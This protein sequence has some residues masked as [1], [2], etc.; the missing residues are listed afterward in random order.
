[1][2]FLLINVGDVGL[3]ESSDARYGEI[4]RAMAADGDYLHP[5]LLGI[6]HYHKPPLTY[7]IT[8]LG[9]HIFGVNA[10]AT[11][12]FLQIAC[13]IQMLLVFKLS[14][15]L[16]PDKHIATH[17]TTI[18][19][20]LPIVLI[21]SRDLT[22]DMYL[23][24]FTLAAIYFW[25]LNQSSKK[26]YYLL[27]C[28]IALGLAFLTKG[29]VVFI[30]YLPFIFIYKKL[31]GKKWVFSIYT[32]LSFL[33]FICIGGSWY[34]Y[35]ILKNPDFFQYF[36]GDQ[37]LS[38]FA[39]TA[40]FNRNM[41]FWYFI[42]L[43]PL[44]SLPWSLPYIRNGFKQISMSKE[45]RLLLFS[46]LIPLFIFSISSSKRLLYILPFFSLLSIWLALQLKRMNAKQQNKMMYYFGITMGVILLVSPLFSS[47]YCYLPWI[48]GVFGF[49]LLA[50]IQYEHRKIDLDSSIRMV[51]ATVLILILATGIFTSKNQFLVKSN[52]P[53]T[54]FLWQHKL[55]TREVYIYNS[56]KPS[57]N[58]GLKKDCI[59]LH[60]GNP[61][62]NRETQF[63]T[64]DSWKKYLYDL[65]S[66]PESLRLREELNPNRL[67]LVHAK[68]PLRISSRFIVSDLHYKAT[69]GPW[70]IYYN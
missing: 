35:L 58:F 63:E 40:K 23:S 55:N 47:I 62:L 8:A 60:D 53:L 37:T 39:Q 50:Y 11:R 32:T 1:M 31:Y 34:V 42:V 48:F 25:V 67:V 33:T 30:F 13:I 56:R 10:F 54:D 26:Q 19:F 38:R 9:I 36:V 57:I 41:P 5:K 3:M 27:L 44:V 43:M 2:I 70:E 51:F 65:E 20:S 64:N 69:L 49:I 45:S 28:S 15:K 61:N 29:P 17:A 4:G 68:N 21:A 24:L 66:I 22:T 16:I 6:H 59:F 46:F 12:F 18:F 7:Q 52:K 14:Y